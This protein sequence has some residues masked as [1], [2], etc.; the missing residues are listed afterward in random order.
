MKKKKDL[1]IIILLS[2]VML[3]LGIIIGY[4]LG[5]G[6]ESAPA[7]GIGQITAKENLSIMSLT[8]EGE[9]MALETTYGVFR[10]PFAFSD[11]IEV[12]A[13][14]EGGASQ[15]RFYTKIEGRKIKNYT[16]HYNDNEGTA[17][18]ILK[19]KEEI[20]VSVVFESYPESLPGDW[21]STFNAVQET[22]NDILKSMMEDKNFSAV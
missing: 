15:L 21:L 16:V 8:E 12:E 17:C 10:Y 2:F 3:A 22:F 1:G 5:S 4:S 14:N 9:W 13:F 7:A 19:M 18:G 11:V 6:N 20:P